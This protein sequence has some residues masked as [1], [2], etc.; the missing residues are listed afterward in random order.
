M[1]L[2]NYPGTL[3]LSLD[4]PTM[5]TPAF[6]VAVHA[7]LMDRG[8][9]GVNIVGHSFGTNLISAF[10]REFQDKVDRITLLDPACLL[11]TF[12][13]ICWNVFYR[14]PYSALTFGMWYGMTS[15]LTVVHTMYRHLW[16]YESVLW[17][18]DLPPRIQ[19]FVGAASE[20]VVL[21]PKVQKLALI[22]LYFDPVSVPPF[23]DGSDDPHPLLTPITS[24][25]PLRV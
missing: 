23:C 24:I 1:L 5:S 6:A 14:R 7:I 9:E 10:L 13:D 11:I 8:N 19:V 21:N 18:E 4:V 17:L 12:S 25:T 22:F 3:V 20:D 2:V 15:E 16:W